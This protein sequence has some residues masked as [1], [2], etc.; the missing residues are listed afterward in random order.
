MN[1]Q[2]ALW[3]GFNLFV[4]AMLAMDLGLF[5]RKEHA[6]SPKEAGIW[7]GVWITLSMLFCGGLW[8]FGFW[9]KA[10]SLQW[11][12]AYVVEYA[13]SVDNLFVFLMVFAYFRVAAGG[14]STGCSSGASSAR[15]S[16]APPS[17]WPAPRSSTASTGCS[18]S[19]AASSSSPR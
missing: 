6:V 10:Q 8:Y 18:T 16:C 15:S 14:A 1:T 9:D 17:S 4:V 11:V 2:S 13:L 3:L 5:H 7:T 12:T 19:S